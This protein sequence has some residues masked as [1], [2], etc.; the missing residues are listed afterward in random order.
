MTQAQGTSLTKTAAD[1]IQVQVASDDALTVWLRDQLEMRHD[2]MMA[3]YVMVGHI[4]VS[5]NINE[6]SRWAAAPHNASRAA[7]LSVKIRRLAADY[8]NVR[9]SHCD[10]AIQV[11]WPDKSLT[12]CLIA[13]DGER[14]HDLS[15]TEPPTT[16]GLT[17]QLMRHNEVVL[18]LAT[19]SFLQSQDVS[20]RLIDKLQKRVEFLE[21]GRYKVLEQ[22]EKLMDAQAERTAELTRAQASEIRKQLGFQQL[23]DLAPI[24]KTKLLEV[25]TGQKL[26]TE[27]PVMN[28]MRGIFDGMDM[29]SLQTML[30]TMPPEKQVA[31]LEIYRAVHAMPKRQDQPPAP[32]A[33]GGVQ[34]P[35]AP[36][37]ETPPLQLVPAEGTQPK[38]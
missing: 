5:A 16:E 28:L 33:E 8:A 6:L 22:A 32:S 10:F 19:Q 37:A 27:H 4:N 1:A 11:W 12:H 26:A 14:R 24:V 36:P 29:A 30:N 25:V 17:K 23:M 31:V 21:E 3:D 13:V 2:G 9:A 7:E 15:A 34:V 18:K 35:P 38:T 20:E